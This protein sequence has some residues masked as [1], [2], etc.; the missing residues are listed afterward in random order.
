MLNM[1]QG[2]IEKDVGKV[3]VFDLWKWPIHDNLPY[4]DVSG[5][6]HT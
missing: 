6:K 3:F 5:T 4:W 1:C 2:S